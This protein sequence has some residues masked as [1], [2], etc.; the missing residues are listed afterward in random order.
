MNRMLSIITLT[1]AA[2]SSSCAAVQSGFYKGVEKCDKTEVEVS[3]TLDV[4]KS[5]VKDFKSHHRC[6]DGKSVY[7]WNPE[8]VIEVQQDGRFNYK[9]QYGS[10][11]SGRIVPGGKAKGEFIQPVSTIGCNDGNFYPPCRTWS[12]SRSNQ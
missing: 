5:I 6:A 3:F 1:L 2:A 10:T 11:V 9:D 4:T 12:V 7:Q 8:A